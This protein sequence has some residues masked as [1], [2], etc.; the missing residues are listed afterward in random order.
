MLKSLI[1]TLLTVVALL[2]GSATFAQMTYTDLVRVNRMHQG[3]SGLRSM[4]D[5]EHYTVISAA[6]LFVT[7]MLTPRCATHSIRV[8]S[9]RINSRPTRI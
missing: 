2:C 7:A 4:Q 9:R 5:G 3:V 1:K 8:A 6:R